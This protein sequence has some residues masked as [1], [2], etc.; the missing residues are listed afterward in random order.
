VPLLGPIVQKVVHHLVIQNLKGIMEGIKRRA[1][2]SAQ[3]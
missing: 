2:E 3:A 1:E